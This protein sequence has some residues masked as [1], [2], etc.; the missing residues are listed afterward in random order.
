MWVV[1]VLL[2][3]P[4]RSMFR[5]TRK[6]ENSP[7]QSL[8]P[9]VTRSLTGQDQYRFLPRSSISNA[10][11]LLLEAF[12]PSLLGS[13]SQVSTTLSLMGRA[14]ATIQGKFQ[15]M[16]STSYSIPIY[17]FL[18]LHCR[19]IHIY[20]S[21]NPHYVNV[22]VAP[23]G[24]ML[25]CK[26]YMVS[27]IIT[28]IIISVNGCFGDMEFY[29]FSGSFY[30]HALMVVAYC[31][32]LVIDW[33]L[34]FVEGGEGFRSLEFSVIGSRSKRIMHRGLADLWTAEDL[35]R[36]GNNREKGLKM[37]AARTARPKL[38]YFHDYYV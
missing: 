8:L 25:F 37:K 13:K 30:G 36:R 3:P 28:I 10:R 5:S 14:I 4:E 33:L 1:K 23:D 20:L 31:V 27:V 21:I 32:L 16:A 34:C 35:E 29:G 22:F 26:L 18:S 12:R 7:A 11:I 19:L 17:V 24:Q 15:G 6:V 9:R 38:Y 2:R